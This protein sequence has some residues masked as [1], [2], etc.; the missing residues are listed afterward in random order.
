LKRQYLLEQKQ[1]QEKEL[2][3]EPFSVSGAKNKTLSLNQYV[4]KSSLNSAL[5]SMNQIDL[6][7]VIEVLT[8]GCRFLDF[9]VFNMILLH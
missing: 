4:I 1:K 5:N 2:Q 7:M 9:E 6:G 3:I 8:K